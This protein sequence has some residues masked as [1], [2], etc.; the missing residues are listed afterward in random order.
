MTDEEF[1]AEK[2]LK[3]KIAKATQ[4]LLPLNLKSFFRLLVIG[5][6]LPDGTYIALG[7]I[8]KTYTIHPKLKATAMNNEF[9]FYNEST[10]KA[11]PKYGTLKC[12]ELEELT[13]LLRDASK[14]LFQEN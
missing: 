6:N 2:I 7:D 4:G 1:E 3:D 10:S 9:K 5:F 11:N 8:D 12:K 14:N 13:T